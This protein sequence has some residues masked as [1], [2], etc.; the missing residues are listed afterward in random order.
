MHLEL[1][2]LTTPLQWKENFIELLTD[3]IAVAPRRLFPL[4]LRTYGLRT[5]PYEK[6]YIQCKDCYNLF[7]HK[8]QGQFIIY[9]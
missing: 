4:F 6:I 8:G 5:I 2:W 9:R 3:F 1:Y 7:M